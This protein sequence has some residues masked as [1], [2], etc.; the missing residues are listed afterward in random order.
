M[1]LELS[2][3]EV[4]GCE[5]CSLEMMLMEWCG[6]NKLQFPIK[7]IKSNCFANVD[8]QIWNSEIQAV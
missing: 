8:C 2:A 4:A 1:C 6:L 3:V 7:F 5:W